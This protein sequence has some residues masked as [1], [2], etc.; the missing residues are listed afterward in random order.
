[1]PC[2][3]YEP[4]KASPTQAIKASPTPP[5]RSSEWAQ[6]RA[7]LA[8]PAAQLLKKLLGWDEESINDTQRGYLTADDAASSTEGFLEDAV[9]EDNIVKDTDRANVQGLPWA[10]DFAK[11]PPTN[12]AVQ[13]R[14]TLIEAP[15][16][17]NGIAIPGGDT[18]G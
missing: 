1:M 18:F 15:A 4:I 5:I 10:M 7:W 13:T 16:K 14:A 8:Q 17:A 12:D 2:P 6:L 11:S 9:E 3:D